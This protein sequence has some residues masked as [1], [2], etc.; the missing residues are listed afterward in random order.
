MAARG[1]RPFPVGKRSTVSQ[2]SL[3][4][5]AEIGVFVRVVEDRGFAAAARS[6][7]ITTSAV[8]K[9][10]GRLEASLG[11]RLLHRTTRHVSLTEAGATFYQRCLRI[12]A[13]IEAAEEAVSRLRSGPRGT[14]RVSAPM[15]FGQLHVAPVIPEFLERYPEVRID[16]TLNDRV[17][18]LV[19]EGFDLAIRIGRLADSSLVARKVAPS[20]RV[21]CG[22]PAYFDRRGVP[23]HP[24][25]LVHHDCLVYTYQ[26]QPEWT[27]RDGKSELKVA[28]TGRFRANNGDVLHTAALAG[29]G[30][31][32]LPT[33]IVGDDLRAGTLRSVLDDYECKETAVFAVYPPSRNPSPKVRAFVDFLVAR[34][35]ENPAW[36]RDLGL[37]DGPRRGAGRAVAR[38]PDRR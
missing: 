1:S 13:E 21:I 19:E 23:A 35:G 18:D 9:G 2:E 27:L 11:T 31:A 36:D 16:M 29:A 38:L 5:I 26:A 17:V 12:L 3:A 28:V 33:F 7:G 34:C 10:V 14:L 32:L 15:S 20:R 22:A 8:S 24:R 6:L 30:I 37:P 4:A 25:D